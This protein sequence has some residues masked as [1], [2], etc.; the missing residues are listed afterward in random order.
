MLPQMRHPDHGRASQLTIDAC[1]LSGLEKID[2]HQ[3]VWRPKSIYH[4]IQFNNINPDFVVD[5]SEYFDKKLKLLSSINL[6]FMI[7]T[8]MKQILLFLLKIFLIV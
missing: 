4:Y 1:F 6:N 2:T 7:L 5:I 8:Q 3:D